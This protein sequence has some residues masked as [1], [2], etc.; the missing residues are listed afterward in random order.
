MEG[1][2]PKPASKVPRE[3]L[4][5]FADWLAR[6][7]LED[8]EKRLSGKADGIEVKVE[9]SDEWPHIVE[10]EVNVITK[11]RPRK[12]VKHEINAALDSVFNELAEIASQEGLKPAG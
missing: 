3:K 2:R 10:A 9:I 1:G 8:V 6:R 11:K 12:G 5:E 7:I 4:E